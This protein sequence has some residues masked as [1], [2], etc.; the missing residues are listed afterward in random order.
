LKKKYCN[1]L[2]EALQSKNEEHRFSYS[3]YFQPF[4]LSL[5]MDTLEL[6]SFISSLLGIISFLDILPKYL[7][8]T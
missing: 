2:A 5:S 4:I 7:K 6:I 1:S 8:K 3:F